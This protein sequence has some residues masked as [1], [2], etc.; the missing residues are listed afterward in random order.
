[1]QQEQWEEE[2]QAPRRRSPGRD[3]RS[4]RPD[5]RRSPAGAWHSE[6]RR[7]ASRDSNGS[8]RHHSKKRRRDTDDSRARRDARNAEVRRGLGFRVLAGGQRGAKRPLAR[9]F[10]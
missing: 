1:M 3:A 6:R 10:F 2:E 4:A 7:E 5:R 8:G 9:P